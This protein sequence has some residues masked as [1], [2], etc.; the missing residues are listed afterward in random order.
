MAASQSVGATD[1]AAKTGHRFFND[2]LSVAAMAGI[3][4]PPKGTFGRLTARQNNGVLCL[5]TGNLVLAVKRLTVYERLT[6]E[7]H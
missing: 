3:R 6:H 4:R 1:M 5:S 7:E 2:A